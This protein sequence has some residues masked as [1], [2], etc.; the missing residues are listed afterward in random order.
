M[1]PYWQS[2]LD[3]RI[4]WAVPSDPTAITSLL[5]TNLYYVTDTND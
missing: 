4:V 5:I 3:P 2:F 1:G